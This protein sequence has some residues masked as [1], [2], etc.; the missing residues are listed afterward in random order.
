[1][2][3]L[4]LSHDSNLSYL[5]PKIFLDDVFQAITYKSYVPGAPPAPKPGQLSQPQSQPQPFDGDAQN[6]SRKRGFHDRDDLDPS[7]EQDAFQQ[8]GR[9][10]KQARRGGRGG[11]DDMRGR[12][13]GPI[14]GL[15][16]RP[17]LPPFDPN[18][19]MEA[20][21]QLQAMGLPYPMPKF[22]MGFN[23]GRNQRRKGRCRDFDNKG[24]CSRGS[25][26]PYDHGN[27]SI[28]VP[29]MGPPG[30]GKPFSL[31]LLCTRV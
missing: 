15:P 17:D 4:Q 7:E 14:H 24:Y 11:R 2:I 10:F 18:N 22:P 12:P 25:T 29:P 23:S 3:D 16:A 8:G 5:D 30:D 13:M 31:S 6:G 19:P 27:E 28:F 20:F 26:C 9:A 21:M 1:M